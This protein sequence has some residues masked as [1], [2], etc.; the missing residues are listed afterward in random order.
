MQK[1]IDL[2]KTK[3]SLDKKPNLPKIAVIGVSLFGENL[4]KLLQ[5]YQDSLDEDLRLTSL[6]ISDVH[7]VEHLRKSFYQQSD[8]IMI[9]AKKD[10][11]S[12]KIIMKIM[13]FLKVEDQ[14]II[15][16][17]NGFEK[18]DFSSKLANTV[19]LTDNIDDS[20]RALRILPD[21]LC[22]TSCIAIEFGTIS[23]SLMRKTPL[24]AV[25]REV[26][27]GKI[28][29]S[30][31]DLSQ[32]ESIIFDVYGDRKISMN[33]VDDVYRQI[34]DHDKNTATIV[35]GITPREPIGEIPRVVMLY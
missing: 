18:C 20:Y 14:L 22:L 1:F 15:G 8:L 28:D 10:E 27:N 11:F 7:D 33:I 31:V 3:Y 13:D 19:N 30:N 32:A 29:L 25:V 23:S 5:K 4:I 34:A 26:V 21:L 17:L 9:I 2:H 24:R 12:E 6:N 35:F 16:F